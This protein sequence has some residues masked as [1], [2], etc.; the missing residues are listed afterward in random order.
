MDFGLHLPLM[1]FQ[2]E[3]ISR[4][5]V[6]AA[7]RAAREAGMAGI[8]A[9]DHFLFSTPWLDGPS[10]LAAAIAESGEMELATTISLGVLRG[11]VPLA[12]TLAAID[13]LSGGRL[14]AGVGPGSSQR[15]YDALGVPF[16]ER[17]ARLDE[18]IAMLKALLRGEVPT[19]G[20]FYPAPDSPLA[21]A[22][23]RPGGV[24]VWVGSWGSAAGIRR[25]ARL[26]DGWLASAYNT[27]P[28]G[29]VDALGRLR[30]ELEANG[31]E[32]AG[33]PNALA[34]MWTWVSEDAADAERMLSEVLAPLLRRDP[35]DLRGRVCVGPGE[36]CA[37]IAR[38][39][40]DAGCER[41]YFWPMGEEERQV[42]LM[43]GEVF[44]RIG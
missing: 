5:R 2:S 38:A 4:E 15:D 33:F 25:V 34:S 17:W 13:V 42:E 22:P 31:R 20:R 35:E 37:E 1:E 7:V 44:P 3:G 10:A 26:A 27:T 29:F 12:K 8:T 24:P 16:D 23:A 18:A 40:A 30:S 41:I 36:L 43:A 14:T 6:E 19:A 21:P 32:P 39:Y 9:N 11:P 28:E